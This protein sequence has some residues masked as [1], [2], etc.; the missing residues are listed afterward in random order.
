MCPSGQFALLWG[1]ALQSP[2]YSPDVSNRPLPFL[3]LCPLGLMAFR[4]P[5]RFGLAGVIAKLRQVSSYVRLVSKAPTCLGNS[6]FE[7]QFL[8]SRLSDH[9]AER[10][11]R[12]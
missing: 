7:I 3:S 12:P 11:S 4:F 1:P 2:A 10:R 9:Q 8:P 5:Y 6:R